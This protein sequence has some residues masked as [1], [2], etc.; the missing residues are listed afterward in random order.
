MGDLMKVLGARK[1]NPTKKQLA[2]LAKCTDLAT[3]DLWFDR[4]LT[5]TAAADVF[6]D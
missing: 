6:K 4:S 3:L 2:Q 1:L 5:V